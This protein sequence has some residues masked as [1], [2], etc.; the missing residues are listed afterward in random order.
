MELVVGQTLEFKQF[1]Q[2]S[3]HG[4]A[5]KGHPLR[6]DREKGKT[7]TKAS[8]RAKGEEIHLRMKRGERVKEESMK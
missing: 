6:G 3:C 8:Q 4:K 5:L 2:F 7:E 1:Y